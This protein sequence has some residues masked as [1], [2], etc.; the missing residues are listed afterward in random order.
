MENPS[1]FIRG[2]MKRWFL[3][4]KPNVFVGSL[5]NEIL[6]NT[7][8]YIKRNSDN[9]PIL[10]MT[11]S[12]NCQGFEISDLNNPKRCLINKSGLSLISESFHKNIEKD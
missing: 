12:N 7:L 11:S 2:V 4:I 5:K 10:I 1:D 6:K 8:E 3:E 9:I